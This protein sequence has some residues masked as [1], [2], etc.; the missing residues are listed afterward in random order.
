MDELK[1]EAEQALAAANVP[2]TAHERFRK[3]FQCIQYDPS[4]RAQRGHDVAVLHEVVQHFRQPS[5]G[6]GGTEVAVLAA[7]AVYDRNCPK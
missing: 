1:Q 2:F 4:R 3:S 6:S 7:A 5:H